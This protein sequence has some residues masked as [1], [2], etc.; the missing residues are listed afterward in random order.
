M[1]KLLFAAALAVSGMFA[2]QASAQDYNG[3]IKTN[4][5]G[6]FVG[7]YQLA[8]EHALNE[9]VSVQLSGGLVSRS[10]TLGDYS[11]QDG[12][13]LVIPEARYY[14]DSGMKGLYTGA[15]ARYRSGSSE[16]TDTSGETE[17]KVNR[18]SIGGGLLIGYQ[19]I[20]SDRLAIDLFAGPQYKSVSFEEDEEYA[21]ESY[22]LEGESDGFGGRFGLNIGF[23]F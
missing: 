7:Q 8:Y 17:Y 23:V 16:L 3:A 10:W 19:F 5:F 1:K 22:Q 14:F 2:S 21:D 11:Q 15:F 12:G 13:F 18:N 9:Q 4:L 6:L 20:V